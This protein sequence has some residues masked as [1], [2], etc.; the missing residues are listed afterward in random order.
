MA[1]CHTTDNFVQLGLE[2]WDLVGH[3]P[4]G[5]LRIFIDPSLWQTAR[6]GADIGPLQRAMAQAINDKRARMHG[7]VWMNEEG[8]SMLA[9][10]AEKL[11]V[12]WRTE[13]VPGF[14]PWWADERRGGQFLRDAAMTLRL[15]KARRGEVES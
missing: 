3:K 4:T 11:V 7:P 10:P 13:W 2:H 9:A 8:L 6:I 5:E 1:K 15:S 14:T 12:E